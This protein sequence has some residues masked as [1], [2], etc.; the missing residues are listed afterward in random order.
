M[1]EGSLRYL[2]DSVRQEVLTGLRQQ[3]A[4]L[5][6]ATG[7][8]IDL[9]VEPVFPILRNDPDLAAQAVQFLQTLV[10]RRRLEVLHPAMG[11]EDFPTSPPRCRPSTFFWGCAP[12]RPDQAL[13][14]PLFNPDEGALPWGLIAAAGLLAGLGEPRVAAPGAVRPGGPGGRLGEPYRRGRASIDRENRCTW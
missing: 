8:D 10:G 5:T 6:Q 4:G 7:A 12:R 3:F 9:T 13:H 11:S 14:S 1:L 2:Q